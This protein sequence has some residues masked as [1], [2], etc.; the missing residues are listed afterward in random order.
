[1]PGLPGQ[2]FGFFPEGRLLRKCNDSRQLTGC[3][4]GEN[5]CVAG[6]QPESSLC[7]W[8]G[9]SSLLKNLHCL[10]HIRNSEDYERCIGSGLGS[11]VAVV[12]VNS[13]FAEPRCG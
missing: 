4:R 11:T 10:T 6:L 1:M 5:P 3:P 9:G 2:S 7:R 12:D 8:A 13:G